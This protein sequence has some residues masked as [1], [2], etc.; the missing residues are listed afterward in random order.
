MP[1]SS[2]LLLLALLVLVA[3]FVARPLFSPEAA[4]DNPT[5]EGLSPWFAER[6]RVLDAL[7]ELDAD[8]QMGKVPED[9]YSAQRQQLLDK[10]AIALKKLEH[11]GRIPTRPS[12]AL[13]DTQLERMIAA[14]RANRKK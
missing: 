12:T 7:A 13:D 4:D 2:V 6:E 3:P 1:L 8:W 5:L 11:L 9:L 14:R 10:G